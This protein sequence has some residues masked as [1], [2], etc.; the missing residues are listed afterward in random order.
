MGKNFEKEKF[1]ILYDNIDDITVKEIYEYAKKGYEKAIK[2]FG[3]KPLK[4]EITIYVYDDTQDFQLSVFGRLREKWGVINLSGN[5]IINVVSPLNPG[6]YHKKEDI[7]KI[8]SKTAADIVLNHYFK[9][10]PKW[11]DITTYIIGVNN[12][13]F[14]KYKPSIIEAKKRENNYINCY[15]ITRYIAEK[16]GKEKGI[17]IL[18]NPTKYNEILKLTDEEIDKELEK[19]YK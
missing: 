3:V 9:D 1:K 7:L 17:E 12:E 4:E 16:F 8:I 18:K 14:P 15:Y 10:F 13:E 19:F 5:T 6:E 11:F 2:F